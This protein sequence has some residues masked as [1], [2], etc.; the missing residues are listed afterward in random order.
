VDGV[1]HLNTRRLD[2]SQTTELPGTEGARGPFFSPDG[3]WVGFEASGKLKKTPLEGGSPV[4]LCDSTNLFGASWGENGNII[5]AL[6]GNALARIPAS[7]GPP[8]IIL[9]LAGESTMPAWPQALPG[10]KLILFTAISFPGPN[11][12]SIEALSLH[13][14]GCAGTGLA[15]LY[16]WHRTGSDNFW[17]R[18]ASS[19]SDANE[20]V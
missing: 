15:S 6:G 8:A 4:V 11:H 16:W 18:P 19:E 9:N 5:A 17:R 14:F 13:F 20:N 1:T 12:G 7:G 3:G 10:T 2:Q